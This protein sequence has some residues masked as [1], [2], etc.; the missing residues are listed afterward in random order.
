MRHIR[1]VAIYCSSSMYT[2]YTYLCTQKGHTDKRR[3]SYWNQEDQCHNF[4]AG[5]GLSYTGGTSTTVMMMMIRIRIRI[6]M[7]IR[8]RI[9]IIVQWSFLFQTPFIS[10]AFGRWKT[11]ASESPRCYCEA[12]GFEL[13]FG[14]DEL[15][16]SLPSLT[17][18]PASANSRKGGKRGNEAARFF[19]SECSP[20]TLL[21]ELL[22]QRHCIHVSW[23]FEGKVGW[24]SNEFFQIPN[25]ISL[26]RPKRVDLGGP[27]WPL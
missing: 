3:R 4:W 8:I 17:P 13:P 5:P 27:W 15:E 1:Y 16:G 7:M 12:H 18:R 9:T 23:F 25:I 14:R 2:V 20:A 22:K 26:L 6:R 11:G 24:K 19:P 10:A 21:I